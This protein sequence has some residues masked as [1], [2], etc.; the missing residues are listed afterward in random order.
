MKIV[1]EI[2][3]DILSLET[4]LIPTMGALHDGHIELIKEGKKLKLPLI[5][6]I[7]I[8]PIQFNDK[9]D[10]A[11]YPKTIEKDI[12]ILNKLEVDYLFIPDSE[13]IYPSNAF[14]SID[15]GELGRKYEGESRPGHFDGVL[16]VVNRL[17]ELIEPKAAI[18]GKKDA[19]QLFLIKK[20]ILD[21]KYK[22]QIIECKTVRDNNGLALSS[23]NVL[24][25]KK[26]ENIATSIKKILNE[27]KKNFLT[28]KDIE[29]SLMETREKLFT[30]NLKIDYLEILDYKTFC[31]PTKISYS[32][33]IVIAAYVEGI[34]L[35]DNLDF[36]LEETL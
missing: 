7:F 11:N 23:R 28:S 36:Q 19:Q 18:F 14:E 30:K 21:K 27:T 3:K 5:V 26:G 22:I 12:E 2:D 34:R 25:S 13:Y 20:L 15:S 17:F 35:I 9:D 33:V 16:T 6:S 31:K 29:K 8:N 10:F 4:C 32:Y 1:K 24:L